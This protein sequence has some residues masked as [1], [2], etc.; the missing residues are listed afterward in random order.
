MANAHRL[1]HPLCLVAFTLTSVSRTPEADACSIIENEA[2]ETDENEKMVDTAA[3][4]MPE[5][6]G[7]TITRGTAGGCS[8]ASSCDDI[9]IVGLRLSSQDDR[10]PTDKIGYRLEL[11]GGEVPRGMTIPSFAVSGSGGSLI[12]G[13]N[14]GS[15][16]SQEEFAFTLRARAVDRAGN[17]SPPLEISIHNGGRRGCAAAGGSSNFGALPIFVLLYGIHWLRNRAPSASSRR[18]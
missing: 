15:T 4:T 6:L 18:R 16:R 12:F 13:W 3:P 2:F 1:L 14:D 8:S 11:V 7:V 10:T 5:N 17:E 9:G